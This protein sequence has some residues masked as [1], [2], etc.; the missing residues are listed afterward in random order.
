MALLPLSSF[1]NPTN[2]RWFFSP[3]D[4]HTPPLPNLPLILYPWTLSSP[5]PAW[6]VHLSTRSS[7][8]LVFPARPWYLIL[9]LLEVLMPRDG[10]IC[11][12]NPHYPFFPHLAPNIVSLRFWKSLSCVDWLICPLDPYTPPLPYWPIIFYLCAFGSPWPALTGSF[13]C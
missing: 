9:A 11:L 6:L 1:P 8:P 13:V 3:P 5:C 4:P 2:S 12:K 7:F 10:F